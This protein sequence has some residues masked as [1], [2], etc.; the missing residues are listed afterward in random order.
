MNNYALIS[1]FNKSSLYK[2]CKIFKKHSIKIISTGATAKHIKKIGYSC[3]EISKLT[4]FKEMLDGRVKTLHPAIHASLLFK[5]N[6]NK[7][8]KSFDSLK[9]SIVLCKLFI[10]SSRVLRFSFLL[11]M[12]SL[13]ISKLLFLLI[14]ASQAIFIH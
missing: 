4:N 3:K 13:I 2:L 10:L 6:N 8:I 9:L 1:V 12:P 7:Q 14:Y 11:L 5:R